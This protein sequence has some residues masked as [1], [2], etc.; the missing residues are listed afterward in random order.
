MAVGTMTEV[1]ETAIPNH[2]SHYNPMMNLRGESQP[3]VIAPLRIP[4]ASAE[5]PF[6]REKQP[7][8]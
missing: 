2:F 8:E 1:R 4:A 3:L 5:N 6:R 7:C